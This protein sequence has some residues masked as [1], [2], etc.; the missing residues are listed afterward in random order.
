MNDFMNGPPFIFKNILRILC[1][2]VRYLC[3]LGVAFLIYANEA[4]QN[5]QTKSV[6]KARLTR[7]EQSIAV[8]GACWRGASTAPRTLHLTQ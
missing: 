1:C 5:S 2:G 6:S 8:Q 3:R 4:T 7:L